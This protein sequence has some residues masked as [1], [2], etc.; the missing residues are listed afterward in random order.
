MQ[1]IWEE[2]KAL[3]YEAIFNATC[4][5]ALIW[6]DVIQVKIMHANERKLTFL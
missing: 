1:F 6:E 5:E 2:F 4:L 3:L